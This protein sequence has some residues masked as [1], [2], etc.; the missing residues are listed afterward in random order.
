[1]MDYNNFT[2]CRYCT[3][4]PRRCESDCEYHLPNTNMAKHEY[5][6]IVIGSCLY[7][8]PTERLFPKCIDD[9]VTVGAAHNILS[10]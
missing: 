9:K 6:N 8:T 2:E 4:E 1:M 10:R 7:F 5:K 3:K